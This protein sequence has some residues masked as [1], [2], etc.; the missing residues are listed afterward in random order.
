MARMRSGSCLDATAEHAEGRAHE[1]TQQDEDDQQKRDA[2]DVGRMP[3]EIEF[4]A[5]E[6]RVGGDTGQPVAAAGPGRCL[7][8]EFVEEVDQRDRQHELRQ[9][10]GSQDDDAADQ[11]GNRSAH[12][13]GKRH[14]QRI[15]DAVMR[16][17]NAGGIGAGAEEGC[18][19]ER[20]H[21]AIAGDEIERQNQKR[22]GDDAGQEREIVGKQEI[23]GIA[24]QRR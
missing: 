16:R 1:D 14:Q 22:N 20:R 24:R 21:T 6:Q 9:S 7:V 15:I 10:V 2:E 11:A 19:A 4:E 13:A 17:G 12:D 3:V 23:A 5:A 8:G 18:M